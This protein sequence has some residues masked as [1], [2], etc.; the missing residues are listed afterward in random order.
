MK[1]KSILIA[2]TVIAVFL[3]ALFLQFIVNS[4]AAKNQEALASETDSSVSLATAKTQNVQNAQNDNDKTANN[5]TDPLVS[6]PSHKA[7]DEKDNSDES[8]NDV[9][10]S[11]LHQSKDHSDTQNAQD[12]ASQEISSYEDLNYV[13]D[14]TFNMIKESYAKIDFSGEFNTG[15]TSKCDFYKKQFIKLL[16]NEVTFKDKD[17]QKEFYLK[18][19]DEISLMEEIGSNISKCTFYFFD[20]DG[21]GVPELGITDC[22]RFIYIFKYD[23][24]SNK[25]LLWY[26]TVAICNNLIG[27]RKAYRDDSSVANEINYA[28]YNLDQHGNEDCSLWFCLRYYPN[29]TNDQAETAYLAS[30]PQ[31]VDESKNAT[32]SDDM[33]KQAYFCDPQNRYYFKITEEQWNELTKKFFDSKKAADENIKK[34]TFTYNELFG[35]LVSAK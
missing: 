27:T 8:S 29:P 13:D 6:T 30:F 26:G 3:L 9:V 4:S 20:A 23:I 22:A 28:F 10:A 14:K 33:K 12:A 16:N 2:A 31:F 25:F 7:Q 21:D 34:V 19:Y 35:T 18:D 17:S 24:N 32:L 15:D 1:N 5:E 11:P